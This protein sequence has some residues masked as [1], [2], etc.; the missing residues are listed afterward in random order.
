MN[1]PARKF[2]FASEDLVRVCIGP[3]ETAADAIAHHEGIGALTHGSAVIIWVMRD[4]EPGFEQA[5]ARC[6][7]CI[8]PAE[9]IAFAKTLM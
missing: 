4:S 8:T 2:Y 9:D 1:A 7:D 3:F 5:R 6:Q